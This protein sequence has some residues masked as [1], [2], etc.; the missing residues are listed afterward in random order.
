MSVKE[1]ILETLKTGP[2]TVDELIAATGAKP[3]V[4]KGQ[5]TRLV[6]AGTVE[7]TPDGRLKLK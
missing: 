2:K 1:K 4:V 6:K 7:R 5:V 3:G